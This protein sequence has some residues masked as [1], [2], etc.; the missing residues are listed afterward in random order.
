MGETLDSGDAAL[1]ARLGAVSAEMATF[2]PREPHHHPTLLGG[3]AGIPYERILIGVAR[4]REAID[5]AIGEGLCAL[6]DRDALMALGYSRMTDYA[7]EVLGLPST[8]ARDKVRL[9]R[10]LV[11]RPLLREAVRS[12]KLTPRKALEVLP[13]ARGDAERPW[14]LLAGTLSVRELHSAVA[15]ARGAPVQGAASPAESPDEERWQLLALPL[16]PEHRVV[17][18]EAMRLAGEILGQGAPA[19]QRL[20]AMALE[21]LGSH[22]VEPREEDLGTRPRPA[23]GGIPPEELE[24]ALEFESNGWDWLEAVEPLAAPELQEMDPEALDAKLQ[25]LVEKRTSW[26]ELF[27]V[28]ARGFVRAGLSQSLGFANLGQYVRERLGM[29]RRAVEQRVWLERRMEDLPQLRHALARGD[30]SYEKARLVAGVADFATVN[31][32]IH[33]AGELTCVDL[34]AAVEAARDAQACARRRLEV[35][36]PERVAG[37]LDEA[38]RA[39]AEAWGGPVDPAGCLALLAR[40]FVQVWGP[41]LERRNDARTRVMERDGGRCTTPGCS[42]ASAQNHHVVRRSQGGGDDPGNLTA[43]CAPH[44]LR[45]IHGELIRVSGTAPHGLVWELRSG[46]RLGPARLRREEAPGSRGDERAGTVDR[47]PVRRWPPISA[48]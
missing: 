27:G 22:P 46:V 30:V 12:G 2:R 37:L 44:H 21:F 34:E 23:E 35:R 40:H 43:V 42:R 6:E 15:R 45:G 7:R 17:V 24:R 29:S 13:V 26:D 33:R 10:G 31:E 11:A 19:W 9:A 48:R 38:L 3:E 32:W 39:V 25:E 36:V 20:E 14:L 1:S 28:L 8:T 47:A 16:R 5:L 41:I 18:E 4:G